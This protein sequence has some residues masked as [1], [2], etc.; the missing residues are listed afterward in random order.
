MKNHN[1]ENTAYL[2]FI[3]D[4]KDMLTDFDISLL[5]KPWCLSEY[6][7]KGDVDYNIPFFIHNYLGPYPK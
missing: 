1:K 4:L 2:N 6:H 3:Q 5:S 7:K